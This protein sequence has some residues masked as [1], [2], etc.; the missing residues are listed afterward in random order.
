MDPNGQITQPAAVAGY[1]KSLA[2]L[3]DMFHG[4]VGAASEG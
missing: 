4:S 1:L 3:A 2:T